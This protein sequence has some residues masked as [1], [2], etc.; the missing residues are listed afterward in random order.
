[1]LSPVN[2]YLQL[3]LDEVRDQD[4]GENAD[5]IDVLKHADSSKLALALCTADGHLYAVGDSEYEFSI[6]SISKP[7]VYA[8]ALDNYLSLIHI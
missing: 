1:M 2:E 5:Y 8:L 3:I 4:S 7:F 6:Q